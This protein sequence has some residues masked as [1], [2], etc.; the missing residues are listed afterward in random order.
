MLDD[1]LT[2]TF[3]FKI[4]VSEISEIF[5]KSLL[6]ARQCNKLQPL[7]KIN[8]SISSTLGC[9]ENLTNIFCHRR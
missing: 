3:T 5:G 2:S 9:G 1:I 7:S 6:N 4:H 8:A